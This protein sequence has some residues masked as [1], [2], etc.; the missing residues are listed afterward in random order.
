MESSERIVKA[1]VRILVRLINLHV[2]GARTGT[3]QPFYD[4]VI[5]DTYDD[6]LRYEIQ[7]WL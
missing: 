6:N 7:N 3:M 5:S 1:S 4:R 2:V